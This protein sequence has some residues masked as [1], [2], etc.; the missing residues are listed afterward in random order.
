MKFVIKSISYFLSIGLI[1]SC[2]SVKE[3]NFQVTEK[4]HEV[5]ALHQDMDLA[6]QILK[7][8]HPGIYWYISKDELDQ[9]FDSVK[10]TINAPLTTSQ[11]YVKLA[12]FVAA[13]KCGHTSIRFPSPVYKTAERERLKTL[14]FPLDQFS[15]HLSANQK[16]YIL[17]SKKDSTVLKNGTEIVEIEGLPVKNIVSNLNKMISN[18]G[19]NQ[20]HYPATLSRYFAQRYAIAYG[21]KDSLRIGYKTQNDSVKTTYVKVI[22]L[23]DKNEKV[24]STNKKETTK[25]KMPKYRGKLE[26]GE[27][28]L[29]FKFLAEN[30][31]FAYLKIKSFSIPSAKYELF[32]KECFD[33]IK[34]AGTQ[35]L[36]IDLRDNGG[37]S[38]DAS[39]NLFAYLTDQPFVYL[40]Q[41]VTNGYFDIRKYG[42][43]YQKIKY[44]LF[45]HNDKDNVSQDK[46]G[47]FYSYMKGYQSLPPHKNN[48]KGK[49]YVLINGYTFSAASLFSAN[50]KGIKRA[51]FVGEETG[52]GFNQCVAGQ[53][54][55]VNLKNSKLQLRFGLYRM[56]PNVKSEMYG[57]GVFPDFAVNSSLQDQLNGVDQELN[58][59]INH[60]KTSK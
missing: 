21:K 3:Y 22:D 5:Q 2:T 6:Y 52:G 38:L 44:F 36:I 49:V 35:N 17:K 24:K 30:K 12:P 39:R 25:V 10:N 37:G 18:D 28:Q 51:T 19:Y 27:P 23:K 45:G 60:S 34:H 11:F 14:L 48:F 29:D 32:Y 7:E 4:K 15:Y 31:Q 47:R 40:D 26:N 46:N 9:K 56:A 50:L 58:W 43:H 53:L 16:L 20:T 42:N 33:S 57:R 55:V 8:N 41:P 54:P 59:I 1:Y 13:I